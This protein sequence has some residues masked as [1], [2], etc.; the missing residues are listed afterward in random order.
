M[1]VIFQGSLLHVL[2][3]KKALIPFSTVTN[4]IDKIRVTQKRKHE[5]LHKELLFPLKPSLIELL[6]SYNLLTSI[7]PVIKKEIGKY[8]EKSSRQERNRRMYLTSTF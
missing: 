5:N 3:D 2:I 7:M 6:N 1:E 4:Q 8:G